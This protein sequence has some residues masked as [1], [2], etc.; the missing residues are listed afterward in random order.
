M[1]SYIAIFPFFHLD[2]IYQLN[3]LSIENLEGFL[4]FTSLSD[5]FNSVK[6]VLITQNII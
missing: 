4:S 5:S 3:F 2:S 6:H 1:K